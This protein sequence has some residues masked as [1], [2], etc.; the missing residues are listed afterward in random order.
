MAPAAKALGL[1]DPMIVQ[2]LKWIWGIVSRGDFGIS[3]EWQQPV[4]GLIWER[5]FWALTF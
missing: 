4:S 2:S 5:N 3:F 1:D